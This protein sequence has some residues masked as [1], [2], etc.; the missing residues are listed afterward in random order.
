M[1]N[2]GKHGATRCWVPLRFNPHTDRSSQSSHPRHNHHHVH[3]HPQP[4]QPQNYKKATSENLPGGTHSPHIQRP[5]CARYSFLG[6]YS[7]LTTCVTKARLE[8]ALHS[9]SRHPIDVG[10]S[11]WFWQRATFEFRYHSTL[12]RRNIILRNG[13]QR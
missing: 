6:V 1:S 7:Y 12:A 11:T 4:S 3:M 13:Y 2:Q 8:N 9:L 10:H 5:Y